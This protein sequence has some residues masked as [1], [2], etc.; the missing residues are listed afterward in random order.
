MAVSIHRVSGELSLASEKN[1]MAIGVQ[2]TLPSLCAPCCAIA[3]RCVSRKAVMCAV[4]TG[5]DM[6]FAEIEWV[7]GLLVKG[8]CG[9]LRKERC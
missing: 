3:R 4:M 9:K 8:K 6:S 7:I 2:N 5:W 1:Q